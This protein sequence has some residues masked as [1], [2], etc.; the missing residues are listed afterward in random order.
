MNQLDRSYMNN[1]E[2]NLDNQIH[3]NLYCE[4]PI[5]L[6]LALF[7][8]T[9]DNQSNGVCSME[10]T[11]KKESEGCLEQFP[12]IKYMHD[13]DLNCLEKII[14]SSLQDMNSIYICAIDYS[15]AINGEG[16]DFSSL[17]GRLD[18]VTN[19]K[20]LHSIHMD[21]YKTGYVY[22]LCRIFLNEGRFWLEEI[23]DVLSLEEAYN[24]IPGFSAICNQ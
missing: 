19:N 16:T 17:G 7:Y 23:N 14:I 2:L 15:S 6:D 9:K 4:E 22:L 13:Y 24:N 18:F 1:I 21:N 20:L 11:G 5:D 12:H 3:A 10:Y 8:Q